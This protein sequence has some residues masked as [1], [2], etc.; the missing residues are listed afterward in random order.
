M[1]SQEKYNAIEEISALRSECIDL[2]NSAA[3]MNLNNSQNEFRI[4]IPFFILSGKDFL[5]QAMLLL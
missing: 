2:I 3:A 5:E 4:I 1:I